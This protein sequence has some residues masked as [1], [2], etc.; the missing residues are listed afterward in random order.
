[1]K[2]WLQRIGL[3]F[4]DVGH[5]NPVIPP[6][7]SPKG[8]TINRP[9]GRPTGFQGWGWESIQLN[10]VR[11]RGNNN[12]VMKQILLLRHAKSSWDDSS[13]EDF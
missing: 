3:P 1:M 4:E 5:L 8:V 10:K 2:P 13:L 7:S 12:R 9:S 6:R 11:E